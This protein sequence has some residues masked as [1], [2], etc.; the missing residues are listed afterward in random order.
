MLF[1]EHL[2]YNPKHILKKF[3]D[4]KQIVTREEVLTLSADEIQKR[5]EENFVYDEYAW[6]LENKVEITS[7][8]RANNIHKILYQCPHCKK[9]F[10]TYSKG[11]KIWCQDCGKVWEM[12]TLGRLHCENGEDIFTSPVDWYKWERANVREQVR[13]GSYHF[14]DEVRLEHLDNSRYGFLNW[15]PLTVVSLNLATTSSLMSSV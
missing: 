5:I 9:E 10:T 12:D 8:A 14:E 15:E 7:K 3:K 2:I 4:D 6:Q 1:C 11:T 13:N